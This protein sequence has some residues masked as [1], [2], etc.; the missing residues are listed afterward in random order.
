MQGFNDLETALDDIESAK[1]VIVQSGASKRALNSFLS[2]I[3]Y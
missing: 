1:N 2:R 3:N